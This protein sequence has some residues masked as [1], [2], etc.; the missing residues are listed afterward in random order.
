MKTTLHLTSATQMELPKD[1]CARKKIGK[2]S[3]LRA[4]EIGGGIFL[5]PQEE[6]T[7]DELRQVLAEAG[8]LAGD[9]SPEEEALVQGLIKEYRVEKRGG[10]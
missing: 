3:A 5:K 8:S 1:F 9:Q 10:K 7:L 2:G 6:P 4:V